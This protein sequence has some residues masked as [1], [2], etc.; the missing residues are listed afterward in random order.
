MCMTAPGIDD[1]GKVRFKKKL[2]V[3]GTETPTVTS[4]GD[5][6]AVDRQ[7]TIYSYDKTGKLLWKNERFKEE[8]PVLPLIGTD[9]AAGPDGTVVFGLRGSSQDP[10]NGSRFIALDG[11]GKEKWS[12][13]TDSEI[14]DYDDPSIDQATGTVY[15]GNGRKSEE[16]MAVDRDGKLLW[17]KNVGPPL[18]IT[19]MP[20]GKGVIV[21]IRGG[22]LHAFDR[23]GNSLWTFHTGNIF[24]KPSFGPDGTVF[25]GCSKTLYALETRERYLEKEMAKGKEQAFGEEEKRTEV[26]ETSEWIIIDGVKMPIRN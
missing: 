12:F 4:N 26:E 22:D 19:A 8:K 21:A 11:Q 6:V 7:N 5:I 9:L 20:D 2:E 16:I 17:K 13:R 14:G 1:R 23:E 25:V 18:H 3:W 15:C 24:T 10:V